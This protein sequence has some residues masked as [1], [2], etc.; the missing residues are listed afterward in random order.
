M[1]SRRGAYMFIYVEKDGRFRHVSF[2]PACK[3]VAIG[4][5]SK[6]AQPMRQMY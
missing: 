2:V 4:D 5:A 3:P 1:D 6:E